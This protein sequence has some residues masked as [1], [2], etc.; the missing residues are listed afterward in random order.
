MSKV[1]KVTLQ[2]DD[3]KSVTYVIADNFINAIADKPYFIGILTDA[4]TGEQTRLIDRMF[5]PLGVEKE[6]IDNWISQNNREE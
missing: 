6:D 3:K 5:G 1:L 2:V 4:K